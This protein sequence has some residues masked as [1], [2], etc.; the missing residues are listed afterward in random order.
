MRTEPI[1]NQ[2]A[3]PWY[4][5]RWP[6]LLMAGPVAVLIAGFITMWISFSGADALVVDDYY[7]QGKAINQ[8]LHRD[9]AAIS[10]GLS[11]ALRYDAARGVLIGQISGARAAQSVQ[12]R[13]I[14]PTM[15]GK[16]LRF[17]LTTDP[18]GTFSVA[19]PLLERAHWQ[20]QLEDTDRQWRLHSRWAWPAQRSIDIQPLK[21]PS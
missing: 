9:Q 15:P 17:S 1:N 7:K 5:H 18:S 3:H 16:D 6:W 4:R 19:L 21:Q 12:L 20:I 8:D 14:H 2:Q 13:L 11:A 10:L